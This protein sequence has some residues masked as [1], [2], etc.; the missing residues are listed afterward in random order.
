MSNN[1]ANNAAPNQENQ[2]QNPNTAHDNI[3]RSETVLEQT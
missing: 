1:E 3:E 2:T